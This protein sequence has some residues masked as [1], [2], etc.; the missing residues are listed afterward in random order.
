MII[1]RQIAVLLTMSVFGMVFILFIIGLLSMTYTESA[2]YL[3][4][5]LRDWLARIIKWTSTRE[6]TGM[7]INERPFVNPALDYHPFH[8]VPNVN[9]LRCF[10]SQQAVI[11][12]QREEIDRLKLVYLATKNY[13]RDYIEPKLSQGT[14]GACVSPQYVSLTEAI[15]SFEEGLK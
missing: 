4:L 14:Q 9:C 1:A 13:I 5:K 2:K 8:S 11:G 15:D 6:V 12:K 3:D 7:D 10:E